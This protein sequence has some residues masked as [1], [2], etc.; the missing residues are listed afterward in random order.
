MPPACLDDEFVAL[1]VGKGDAFFLRRGEFTALIDGG[2]ARAGFCGLFWTTLRRNSVNVLVCTHNDADH[3]NG[4]IGFLESCLACDEVWLP[5]LWGDRLTDLLNKPAVFVKE[6]AEDIGGQRQSTLQKIADELGEV[7]TG[8]VPTQEPPQAAPGHGEFLELEQ[9]PDRADND[10]WPYGSI[11]HPKH[12]MFMLY[13][14]GPL[15][16]EAIQ[17][18]ERIREVA[19]AAANRG[20]PIR[21]FRYSNT[22]AHGGNN[23]LRPLN[24]I[25]VARSYRKVSALNYL[26]LS[27]SNKLSLVYQSPSIDDQANVIFTADSNLDFNAQINWGVRSIITAP[28]HGSEANAIAYGRFSRETKDRQPAAIWVRSDGRFKSRPGRSYLSQADKYCTICRSASPKQTVSFT[29]S[30]GSWLAT[31][32]TRQCNC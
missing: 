23:Q 29:S 32:Q 5:A 1:P 14:L 3:A 30:N 13:E 15:M 27:V 11:I 7:P 26:A 28:H 20:I 18:M 12:L 8:D 19:I 22:S 17:A 16:L 25:E 24:A 31:K 9:D 10:P 4:I 2:I 6:L 21:W